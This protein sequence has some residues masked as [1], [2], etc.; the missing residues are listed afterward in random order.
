MRA[1]VILLAGQAMASMDAS[2]LAVAA[3]S[4]R[5]DLHPSDAQ[6]QLV[7][8]TYTIALAVLVVT[9]ARLGDILGRRRAFVLGLAGFTVASLAGGLAPT[10][11]A[12]IVARAA[13]GA[14]AAVMVPQ[15][16]SIIQVEFAGERRARAI[17]AYS[18]ILAAGVAAGQVLGGLLVGA[19]LL[20]DAWRP[21]LLL[22]AP[23]GAVLLVAARRFLPAAGAGTGAKLDLGGAAVL[24]VAILGLVVPLTFGRDAG[25]PTWIWPCLAAFVLALAGFVAIERRVRVPLF[26]LRVLRLPAIAAGIGAVVLIMACYA[27]FL[28][29]LTL[30][31]QDGLGFSPLHAGLTFAVYAGGFAA[32]SLTWTRCGEGV[33]QRLPWLGPLA[34]G[35][36]LLGVGLIAAGGGWPL[37]LT[38]PLLFLAGAG[39]ACGFSP[40]TNR[41]AGAVRPDQ[42]GDLSGL[43]LT[44]SLIGQVLGVAAFTGVYLGAASGGSSHAL[45]ATTVALAATLAATAVFAFAAVTDRKERKG[46]LPS[47]RRS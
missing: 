11:G 46:W 38:A 34:M 32:T 6:L 5:A 28:I 21:A 26:D 39:H 45:A 23:V 13:Q 3:P 15:V 17:G 7:V 9:G 1:L 44:A 20:D 8:A 25:W 27:G 22:N 16:L 14:T 41:L 4:L 10:T 18:M 2:I 33:R 19:H 12:L 31:L 47:A 35:T 30:H 37:G 42:A 40:L 43:V 24:S 36:A 29:S